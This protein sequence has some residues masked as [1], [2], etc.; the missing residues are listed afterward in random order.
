MTKR[1][2]VRR[3]R[4]PLRA[5]TMAPFTLALQTAGFGT[6]GTTLFEG[7]DADIPSSSSTGPAIISV[8][9]TGGARD[10]KTHDSQYVA[11]PSFQITVRH[12]RLPVA[13]TLIHAIHAWCREQSNVTLGGRFWLWIR[14]DQRPFD[15]GKD[16]SQRTLMTFNVST[17]VRD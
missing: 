17:A 13:S 2:P 5:Q 16:A 10:N 3:K 1:K 6:Y 4:P 15:R 12:A 9:E 14:P 11:E 8:R 7:P